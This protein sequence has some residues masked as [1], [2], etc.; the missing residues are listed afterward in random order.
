MGHTEDEPNT[1]LH[2]LANIMS[3]LLYQNRG[4]LLRPASA[5]GGPSV[6]ALLMQL[7]PPLVWGRL[8][9]VSEADSCETAD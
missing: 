9:R 5:G 1:S 3:A 2:K 4:M 6:A 7:E 8:R